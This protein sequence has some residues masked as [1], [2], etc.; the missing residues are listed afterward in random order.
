MNEMLRL[1]T[2]I[3]LTNET[4]RDMIQHAGEE[5]SFE[6]A[7]HAIEG[8]RTAWEYNRQLAGIIDALTKT[9]LAIEETEN[10]GSNR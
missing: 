4:L 1:C 5:S 6:R 7:T 10:V 9:L 3:A 2:A 8:F